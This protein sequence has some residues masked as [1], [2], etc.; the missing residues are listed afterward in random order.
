MNDI[1]LF[2][3]FGYSV[4][5]LSA[6]SDVSWPKL[7]IFASVKLNAYSFENLE[8]YLS[9]YFAL[10]Q[11]IDVGVRRRRRVPRCLVRQVGDVQITNLIASVTA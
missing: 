11:P 6:A 3:S 7:H 4:F 5:I 8:T 1:N 2:P 9:S 10:T